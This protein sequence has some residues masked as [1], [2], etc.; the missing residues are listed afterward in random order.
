MIYLL[1]YPLF[2]G[3][4]YEYFGSYFPTDSTIFQWS[5]LV[6]TKESFPSVEPLTASSYRT[7]IESHV[8]RIQNV[9]NVCAKLNLIAEISDT[10]IRFAYS[11][12]YNF[13]CFPIAKLDL[14]S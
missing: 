13:A 3:F 11:K 9:K 1:H 14:H 7:A 6:M 8:Q 12:K 10:A 4:T 5:P 2:T